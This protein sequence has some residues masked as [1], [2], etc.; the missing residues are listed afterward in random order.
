MV[1]FTHWCRR[2]LAVR[3]GLTL[4]LS[5]GLSC[6]AE[7][8]L[9]KDQPVRDRP[10]PDRPVPDQPVQ[11]QPASWADAKLPSLQGLMLWL[12]ADRIHPARLVNHLDAVG[13]GDR[14]DQWPDASG[15]RRAFIQ[16]KETDQPK[17]VQVGAHWTVRFD[18]ES[19]H[20]RSV[21]NSRQINAMTLLMMVAPHQNLGDFRGFFAAN[22]AGQRDYQSGFNVDLGPAP[23]VIWEQLNVEGAGFSGAR[24][25]L[26]KA[27]LFGKLKLVEVT[28]DPARRLVMTRVDGQE[29]G[30]REFEPKPLAIDQLTL[31][32][33]FYTNGPGEQI[34]RGPLP[35]D[36]AEVLLYDRAL[37]AD[38]RQQ[39]TNY[40]LAK[41][42]ELAEELPKV[43]PLDRPGVPLVKVVDPP[44]VQM[45]LPGF[46]VTEIPLSLSNV[47]NVR[48]RDDGRLVTL[49]Y[50]GDL[51][52]LS[53]SDGDGVEDKA[54]LFWKNE[55][56]LRGPLGL[57]LTPPNYDKGRGVFVPSK[58]KVS[59]IVDT[60]GDDKADEEIVVATG[61]KEISQNV[62]AVGIAMDQEGAIYFG[63]GTANYANA[64]MV[65][66]QG[67]AAFELSSERGTV[68]RI[69]PDLKS[70]STVCTGVR[71]PIA[72][73]FNRHGDLFC[74]EQEGATWLANGNP[75]DELLHIQSGRH[76]G[77]PPR[78]PKYNPTVI[79]EPSTFDY[80][81]QHQST[82]GMVFNQPVNGGPVFGLPHWAED[83]LVCGESRGKI[84]R[85]KLIQTAPGYVASSQL[86][87]CLQMLTVDACVAPNGDLVVA[88]HSGPPD[89]GTGP[90]G[91]GKLF[92]I[93]KIEDGL[94]QP[95]AIWPDSANEVR[96]AFD[97][98]LDPLKLKKFSERVRIEYGQYV[99]GG[100]RF[101]NLVP[102]YAV[103]KRQLVAPR[104]EL[105][106]AS[107]ALTNDRKTMILSTGSMATANYF[108]VSLPRPDAQVDKE[109]EEFTDLDF[110][111]HGIRVAWEPDNPA[112]M[113][114]E[115]LPSWLPHLDLKVARALTVGSVQ[116]DQ[117][118]SALAKPGRLTLQTNLDLY[119]LL[120][121]AIQPG[122][123]ID[124]QWPA[125]QVTLEFECPQSL[126]LTSKRAQVARDGKRYRLS[127]SGDEEQLVD[128]TIELAT[129]T[130]PPDIRLAV[131]TN[132][133]DRLRPF[134]L[135]RFYMPWIKSK[136]LE[137]K[138]QTP[139]AAIEEI[140]GG[141]WGRGRQLFH[142]E[143]A[144]CAKC[145]MLSGTGGKIG[146]DL[147][148]LVHRDYAS[149]L[150]DIVN[151]SFAINP[152]YI[153]HVVALEGGE[154]LT[155]VLRDEQGR[156]ILGDAQGKSTTLDRADV[157]RMQ[158]AQI[159]IMPVGLHEKLTSEQMRDLMTFLLTPAP[160]MPLDSPLKAPSVR[161][162]AEVAA[163]LDGAIP[164]PNDLRPLK[165]VLVAGKKDHGPGE[166][167]YPAWQKQWL[168]LLAAAKNVQVASAWDFPSEDQLST[169]DIVIFF[170]KGTWNDER[171]EALD[172]YFARGGGAVYLHWAVNGDARNVD[173]A[174]R[175]GLA[176]QAGKIRYRHGPLSLKL[177]NTQHP[178]LR[179]LSTL[180]LYDESYWALTG[181]TAKINVLAS[182]EEEGTLHPQVWTYEPSGG[183]VMVCIPGHYNWTFDDP[184]FRILLLR[185]IAWSAREPVDRFN[186]IVP[187]GARISK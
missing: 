144:A 156:L 48:F 104:Y 114:A 138:D 20:L 87:A 137:S 23:S 105:P 113:A 29:M 155:G 5:L 125:E 122:S 18:G 57:L 152:D 54:N 46:Q 51:H 58:G 123:T 45:L 61:W 49:G 148:N 174:K 10:V 88:C 38:E 112:T 26:K 115:Q 161:S 44:P 186:E 96:I 131:Y 74:S 119:H 145:H 79:D 109:R 27:E 53:D 175:I 12:D 55:G 92:R 111:P 158:P 160:Q 66:D 13:D 116:H 76:Y 128:L 99:R 173:F 117:L 56:S 81:P 121:P 28:I 124:Y 147:S 106:V 102:P 178:I 97:R 1:A 126:S 153:G 15:Q 47:N 91:I 36:V 83:A 41:H 89:W 62:D 133:D 84:W 8:Q 72:F 168:Q 140:A 139:S 60:D 127:F 162:Q 107:M 170:Q 93:R 184:L 120:R 136:V 149:V 37:S 3:F 42:A 24:N 75:L 40:L 34:V 21:T 85:T 164:L 163:A 50:N 33:R 77:F 67:K 166:H 183:R 25:L 180:D 19:D 11:D 7:A 80:G 108:A 141:N 130:E 98:P 129:G 157:E 43:L 167:D 95:M 78:H 134:P 64:Y 6:P 101:E 135:H 17:L 132:E 110:A 176:S 154:V 187:L 22:A 65:D 9:V 68:Q 143:A 94:P 90:T 35:V 2:A 182:S 39:L 171:S 142:G 165:V 169:A 177:Q 151:P 146:P 14:L 73:A 32:A 52:L 100:D 71:F 179:N 103:V 185:G 172:R 150:R 4:C 82:C 159:S 69:A 86:I 118:W 16:D 63:L 70:R 30:S 31:A 181:D 59:L